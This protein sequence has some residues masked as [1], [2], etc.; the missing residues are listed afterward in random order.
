MSSPRPPAPRAAHLCRLNTVQKARDE[1]L[2]LARLAGYTGADPDTAATALRARLTSH[3]QPAATPAGRSRRESLW[4]EYH[5]LP[6]ER[7]N[8]FYRAN[9]AAMQEG[10]K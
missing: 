7:R 4:A 3:G 1:I 5:S 9:K 2:S 6:I 10:E 8:E